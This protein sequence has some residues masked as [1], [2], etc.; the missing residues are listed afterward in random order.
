MD[1][2]YIQCKQNDVV[3]NSVANANCVCLGFFSVWDSVQKKINL[4][5]VFVITIVYILLN[6][7]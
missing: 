7:A 4:A 5:S 3:A 2:L 6:N 1:V